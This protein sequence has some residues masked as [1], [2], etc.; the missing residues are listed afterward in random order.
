ME[1]C[2]R[3]WRLLL[4]PF[5]LVIRLLSMVTTLSTVTSV[6]I[7]STVAFVVTDPMVIPVFVAIEIIV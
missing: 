3:T 4:Y 7:L 2:L 1:L 6:V 5:H